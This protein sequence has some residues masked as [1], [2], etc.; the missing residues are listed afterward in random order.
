MRPPRPALH[1]ACALAACAL[2]AGALA[3]CASAQLVDAAVPSEVARVE[4]RERGRTADITLRSGDLYR[5]TLLFLRPD[6]T[7]WREPAGAFVV[8]T[9]SVSGLV[10][11]TWRQSVMRGT[12]VGAGV[13]AGLC[14]ATGDPAYAVVLAVACAPIGAFAGLLGGTVT[15]RRTQYVFSDRPPPPDPAPTAEPAPDAPGGPGTSAPF[16]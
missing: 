11:D 2:A 6:S 14:V 1:A 16:R 13:A 15:A 9:D 7:A 12:F 10:V 4:A 3:G 8:P 5:G